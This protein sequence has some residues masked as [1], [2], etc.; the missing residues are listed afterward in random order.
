MPGIKLVRRSGDNQIYADIQDDAGRQAYY[1]PV[2]SDA[3]TALGL[4]DKN[5]SFKGG[6][7]SS[8]IKGS[9]LDAGG[10][11]S[12]A[13]SLLSKNLSAN[14]GAGNLQ[15]IVNG[16]GGFGVYDT[17][18][19]PTTPAQAANNAKVKG[20]MNAQ[21]NAQQAKEAATPQFSTLAAPTPAGSATVP[22]PGTDQTT[23]E[24][25]SMLAQYKKSFP[26][27]TDEIAIGSVSA[28]IAMKANG[29]TPA[30]PIGSLKT[31]PTGTSPITGEKY[32]PGDLNIYKA[33][34]AVPG[35]TGA[36]PTG[37]DTQPP[38]DDNGMA[39]GQNAAN[40]DA[41]Q[42]L[43]N[44]FH[45]NATNKNKEK[46]TPTARVPLADQIAAMK[47]A[48]AP[49]SAAPVAPNLVDTYK[50]QLT[51]SGVE[52]LQT[53][54]NDLDAQIAEAQAQGRVNINAE[55]GKTVAMNVIAGRV[56]EQERAA[57]E[58]IDFLNR[59]KNYA[60]SQLT[61]KQS[62]IA[63]I[64]SL[65]N[66]DFQNASATYG[67]QFNRNL[68]AIQLVQKAS[69]DEFA[70]DK[71]ASDLDYQNAQLALAAQDNSRANVQILA[72]YLKDNNLDFASLPQASQTG[73]RN[74]LLQAGLPVDFLSLVK[75]SVGKGD[76]ISTTTRTAPNGVKYADIVMRD[77][78]GKITTKELKLGQ[79]TL[80]T[81]SG[82]GSGKLT[83]WEYKIQ[84]NQQASAFLKSYAGADGHVA[85]D[86]WK[87]VKQKY[88]ANGGDSY[89]FVTAFGDTFKDPKNQYYGD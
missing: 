75:S 52:A 12:L 38:I 51:D 43:L 16:T 5:V 70:R 17:N 2:S 47:N 71:Y 21:Y 85:P 39:N 66:Q 76:I 72:S 20:D 4:S 37:G 1:Q 86:A 80:P 7:D 50:K 40:M 67:D 32:T 61:Q 84:N 28:Q 62:M 18:F 83:E 42:E 53:Q 82:G 33:P 6:I 78:D 9:A 19:D 44:K 68:Q 41:L 60:T 69:D 56:S 35:Q 89:D 22:Q 13:Q 65:T 26:G 81:G 79:D 24:F 74:L 45:E 63:T 30:A 27:V 31:V 34:A 36:T 11:K 55:K 49:T 23:P 58:R 8:L 87:A 59:Q 10:I 25:K 54:I 15:D 3:L 29:Q 77:P 46:D 73:A 64:M 88:V 48:I 14:A 57:N